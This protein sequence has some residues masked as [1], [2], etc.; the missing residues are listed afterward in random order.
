MGILNL[1]K[2][3]FIKILKKKSTLLFIIA[4]FISIVF[5]IALVNIRKNSF[6]EDIFRQYDKGWYDFDIDLKQS[7]LNSLKATASDEVKDIIND[8]SDKLIMIKKEKDFEKYFDGYYKLEIL[9]SYIGI[10]SKMVLL[11]K[12]DKEYKN[13]KEEL[14]ILWNLFENASF[15]DYIQYKFDELEKKYNSKLCSESEYLSAKETLENRLK[16]GIKKTNSM[17]DGWKEMVIDHS[18]YIRQIL[19]SKIDMSYPFEIKYVDEKYEKELEKQLFID[20]Y[21]LI[22][23]IAPTDAY[24]YS[25]QQ[26]Y[27]YD[28][29]T[30]IGNHFYAFSVI[31]V[32]FVIGIFACFLSA[33]TIA[34][35]AQSGTI[36]MLFVTPKKRYK[37]LASKLITIIIITIILTI[38]F[39]QIVALVGS[40]LYKSTNYMYVE[41]GKVYEMNNY[42]Y[43]LLLF[44]LKLPEIVIYILIGICFST[45]TRNLAASNIIT[46]A[47]FSVVKFVN[48]LLFG[49]VNI[50]FLRYLP[51]SNFDLESRVLPKIDYFN[52]SAMETL[53]PLSLEFSIVVLSVTAL[54]LIITAFESFNKR[55]I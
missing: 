15:E 3:E 27:S 9:Q 17:T 35:E 40:M 5:C 2:C 1:I 34:E 36:K 7:T 38:I 47:M 8:I 10:P 31:T 13:C 54:L 19:E 51:F 23:N 18:K 48:E 41:N 53:R 26:E 20:E 46:V 24:I 43:I 21:R 28:P 52:Y 49:F 45:I 25:N 29:D 33:S 50:E 37:I 22:N 16:Y 30:Y 44:L 4:I 6:P 39:S 32:M 42:L 11:N 55:D 14:K 12:N